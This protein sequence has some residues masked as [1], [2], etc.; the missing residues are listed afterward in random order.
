MA[1][2]EDLVWWSA[3]W[4]TV[5]ADW[6]NRLARDPSITGRVRESS[7]DDLVEIHWSVVGPLRRRRTATGQPPN[8]TLDAVT[9]HQSALIAAVTAFV[10]TARA[11]I[12]DL[13][14]RAK[15]LRLGASTPMR[16]T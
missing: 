11:A 1:I 3:S 5:P 2:S 10:A 15:G 6:I 7:T 13:G 9:D 12:Q 4:V 16:L 14:S 8:S